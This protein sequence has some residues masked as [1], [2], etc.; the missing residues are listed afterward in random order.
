MDIC[1]F[2]MFW[3]VHIAL[4]KPALPTSNRCELVVCFFCDP[5]QKPVHLCALIHSWFVSWKSTW[6]TTTRSVLPSWSWCSSWMPSSTCAASAASCVSRWAM[7]CCW[8]SGAVGDSHSPSWPVICE[9]EWKNICAVLFAIEMKMIACRESCHFICILQSNEKRV[10]YTVALLIVEVWIPLR[11]TSSASALWLNSY[12]TSC[13]PPNKS[14]LPLSHFLCGI[15]FILPQ[16]G[17]W[18]FPNWVV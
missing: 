3:V 5:H 16:V 12:S 18:V 7:P 10:V 14:S 1:L 9:R 2:F 17:L 11:N 8:G 13:E 6:R 4:L 15:L